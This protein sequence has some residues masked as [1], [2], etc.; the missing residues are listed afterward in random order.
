MKMVNDTVDIIDGKVVN[1]GI[2]FK[3]VVDRDYNRFEIL[4]NCTAALRD[5]FEEPLDMGEPLYLTE[6]YSTL[7]KVRGVIDTEDVVITLK[8]GSQYASTTF[9]VKEATAPDGRSVLAPLNA[10]FEIKFPNQDIRG[11]IK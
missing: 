2:N 7:N 10:A 4:D 11:V 3:V 8:R 6:I 9:S 5:K 1:V